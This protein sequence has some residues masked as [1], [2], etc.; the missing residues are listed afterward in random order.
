VDNE[1]WENLV[2]GID[3]P[4]VENGYVTVPDTPGL[5]VDLV[6]EV[7]EQYLVPGT[8][9]FAPTEEWNEIRSNNRLFS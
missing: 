3:K 5:G 6:D 1:D 7:V 4:L 9:L 2:S 8:E